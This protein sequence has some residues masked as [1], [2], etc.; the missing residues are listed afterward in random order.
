[1][2]CIAAFILAFNLLDA[3]RRKQ[4]PTNISVGI[5]VVSALF[6]YLYVTGGVHGT[7][8][9]WYF[10]YPLIAC[11]LLG[12]RKGAFSSGVMFLP[13]MGL[14]LLQPAHSFFA[15]YSHNFVFR[16]MTSYLVILVFSYLFESTREK[17]REEL[18]NIN[19]SLEKRVAERTRELALVNEQ[20]TADIDK[21]EHAE[22]ALKAKER[23][24]R[25]IVENMS[26][27]ICVHDL[28]GRI[29]ETNLHY[30]A[31]I[32]YANEELIGRHII[33]L[34]APKHQQG[35]KDYLERIKNQ[36]QDEGLMDLVTKS[37]QTLI[38]E[39]SN[40][41]MPGDLGEL[42]VHVFAKDI[43]D[44][45]RA[46]RALEASEKHY[47]TLF[48]KAGD[49]IFIIDASDEKM[50]RI[51]DANQAAADM[52]GYTVAQI[53]QMNIR[54]LDAP[55]EADLMP[56]RISE[57][58]DG[59]WVH[60]EIQHV[61]RD[62]TRFPVEVSAGLIE[63]D[64]ERHIL[65]IDR[66][67]SNRRNL[68]DQIRQ[69]Q[70][71][72][73]IGNLA[74]GIAH[75]FN[76]ILFPITGITELL[77]DDF[78]PGSAVYQKL[79]EILKAGQRAGGLVNQILSFSRQSEKK[80][81]PVSLQLV[82]K[83]VIKLGRSTIPANIEIYSDL[84]WDC[85]PV[86]A[87]PTQ[88]HQIAMNLITNAYHAVEETNGNIAV[89]LQEID[90]TPDALINN[91]LKP[92]C[93]AVLNISDSGSGIDPANMERIFDPYFTTKKKGKGTGLGLAVVYGI[94]TELGG[95][96]KVDS[97]PE[98]GTTFSVFLPLINDPSKDQ[99][100]KQP[101]RSHN[102][103]ESILVVDDE[104]MV[105]NVIG[106]M[107]ERLGYDIT[108]LN[109]SVEALDTFESQP[110]RFDL[111][112]TDMSMP[113]MTG[114]QLASEILAIRPNLPIIICTGYSQR[115]NREKAESIGVKGV[116]HKPVSKPDLAR[117]I[118]K[119][120]NGAKPSGAQQAVTLSV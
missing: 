91:K 120:L 24:Y 116:L 33:D 76:N 71:M 16:F 54:E 13:V 59:K 19:Q 83:E 108:T 17:N 11:Y 31:N 117:M 46:E 115:L 67:I 85:S 72:E 69:S 119:V 106:D 3:K 92:G 118:R 61:R 104:V 70:K 78:Q 53:K 42:E 75:D 80:K 62:G 94:V 27:L 1:V 58:L 48:E 109:S 8:F 21:R 82:L 29:R 6:I 68:E 101:D 84:Q 38:L 113:R 36:G 44:R 18:S 99:A 2:D 4:Y 37:G 34:V 93:Y 39:Y 103:T 43:T 65:A 51:I 10:T 45:W 9:V 97:S 110:D 5:I 60:L 96:I 77:L 12:S 100:C 41:I 52:H 114:D 55:Y 81:V 40:L 57:M 111:M 23:K 50:G 28:D 47:R 105:A 15:S 35:I 49:A 112:I 102:G 56:Q 66:D 86:L 20:L 26:D 98:Q 64:K 25:T 95:E 32:G 30:K 63:L 88:M 89:T 90:V 79:E 73:S 7:A 107:L 14:A 87:D 74:G 22:A